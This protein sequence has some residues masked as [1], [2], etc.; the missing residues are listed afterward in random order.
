VR[1]NGGGVVIGSEFEPGKIIQARA[2]IE[3]AGLSEFVEIREGDALETLADPG[4]SVDMV[5]LDG[6]KEL[7]LP[8]AEM[9]TP[10]LRRGAV[11]LADNILSFRKA[12]APYC[13]H[14]RE[15]ANGFQSVTLYLGDG[16][17]YSVRL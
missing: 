17:E 6:M 12:L 10:H 5:L 14:M 16:T 7:Y 3:E 9:L 1:D 2:H 4:V 13:A 8:I 15:A 11:V